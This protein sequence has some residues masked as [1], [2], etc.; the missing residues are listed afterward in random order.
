MTDRK[1]A[2]CET[3]FAA[4]HL[5]WL[6]LLWALW[7]YRR[8]RASAALALL[9]VWMR[10]VEPNWIA[11]EETVLAAGARAKT[12]VRRAPTKAAGPC[13]C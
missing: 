2:T 6:Y 11:R 7:S 12:C 4:S 9:F 13:C 10:F 5:V 3:M 8:K 1:L